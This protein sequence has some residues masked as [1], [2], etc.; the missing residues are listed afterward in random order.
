[1]VSVL[2]TSRWLPTTPSVFIVFGLLK[3]RPTRSFPSD[4][5]NASERYSTPRDG[6]NTPWGGPHFTPSHEDRHGGK[7]L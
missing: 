1:M 7:H 3:Y 4:E 6:L 5:I 2:D